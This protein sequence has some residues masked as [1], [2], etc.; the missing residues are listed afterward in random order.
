M[1]IRISSQIARNNKEGLL[2]SPI[3]LTDKRAPN[4]MKNDSYY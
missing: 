1:F 3:I 2:K 4:L